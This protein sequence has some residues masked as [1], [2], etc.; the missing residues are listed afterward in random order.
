MKMFIRLSFSTSTVLTARADAVF[1]RRP[2]SPRPNAERIHRDA[3]PCRQTAPAVDALPTRIAVIV[4]NQ[5]LLL[6]LQLA[7]ASIETFEPPLLNERGVIGIGRCRPRDGIRMAHVIEADVP[8]LSTHVLE[9]N[10]ARDDVAVPQRRFRRDST[11][12]F[13]RSADPIE[14]FIGERVWGRAILSI[15]VP[16]EPATRFKVPFTVRIGAVVQP[17]EEARERNLCERGL[18]L[19]PLLCKHGERCMQET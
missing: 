3:E 15:E 7:K 12:L 8:S 6:R 13:Q 9:Q 16:D 11:G 19:S 2:D 14:C 1:E 18:L 5:L 10:K 17:R 4:D